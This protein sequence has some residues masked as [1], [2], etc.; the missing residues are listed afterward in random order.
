MHDQD[1]HA[2]PNQTAAAWIPQHSERSVTCSDPEAAAVAQQQ[3]LDKQQSVCFL[4]N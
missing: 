4:I 2:L 3:L 1:S